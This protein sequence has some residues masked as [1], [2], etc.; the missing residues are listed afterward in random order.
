MT[1]LTERNDP[2]RIDV[3]ERMAAG[4]WLADAIADLDA[5]RGDEREWWNRG[6]HYALLG[7][8]R[9]DGTLYVSSDA[10]WLWLDKT[11]SKAA[12]WSGLVPFDRIADRKNN[13][14]TI[15][16]AEEID[17][18]P[19]SGHSLD[20][21]DLRPSVWLADFHALQPYRIAL[22]A[23]KS[24]A[25]DVLLPL[26]ERYHTELFLPDGEMTDTMIHRMAKAAYTD[27]RLLIVLYFVDADP[28]GYQMPISLSRKLQALE[29]I[30]F[31]GLEF[32]VVQAA[33]LPE[34]VREFDLPE[35]PL[36]DKEKRAN[37]WTEA[38]GVLQTEL[39]SLTSLWPDLFEQ[40]AVE[41]IERFYD[42][43]LESEVE[44]L[45]DEWTEAAQA[46]VDGQADSGEQ[47]RLRHHAQA[48]ID[49]LRDRIE[50]DLDEAEADLPD[51]PEL[52]ESDLDPD[53]VPNTVIDSADSFRTQTRKLI[54]RK[55]YLGG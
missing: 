18:T 29:A 7:R 13:A 45:R 15:R 25:G 4:R 8:T 54:A 14:P 47:Q 52:P 16:L 12:R 23:E 28:S 53:D 21:I 49:A 6:L 33:L 31:P 38:F 43:E 22:V 36:K 2:F 55:K 35:T 50:A 46:V 30:E 42:T 24:S 26:S 51:I 40:I 41:A 10:C 19:E 9:P 27:G 20:D 11:A 44:R 3:E 5:R 34:Q 39:D 37:A 48:A 32:K 17:P 1:V